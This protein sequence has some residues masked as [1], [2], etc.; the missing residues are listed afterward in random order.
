M[1]REFTKPFQAAPEERQE[2]TEALD[3]LGP[4]F[5]LLTRTVD[6]WGKAE[7]ARAKALEK[8]AIDPAYLNLKSAA[9]LLGVSATSFRRWA[10]KYDIPRYGPHQ[11]LYK[12]SDL[13]WFMENPYA[14]LA[15]RPARTRRRRGGFTPVEGSW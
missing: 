1:K 3:T 14:F 10:D 13:H 11:N 15:Q 5:A 8:V 7:K 9:T 2:I 4:E 6:A 12:R